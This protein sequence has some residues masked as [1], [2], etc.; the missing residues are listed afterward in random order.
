MRTRSP[1]DRSGA[2]VR[3]GETASDGQRSG[4]GSGLCNDCAPRRITVECA[5]AESPATSGGGRVN[6]RKIVCA[7][8]GRVG[9]RGVPPPGGGG[10]VLT[11]GRSDA[12]LLQL[13]HADVAVAH[14]LLRIIAAAV[15]LKR[16]P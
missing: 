5:I 1:N 7:T 2:G 3:R 12:L 15:N 9:G 11:D 14:E 6:G 16:D 13:L 8:A 4:T 10:G